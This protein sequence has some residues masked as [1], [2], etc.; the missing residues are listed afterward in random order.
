MTTFPGSQK[1]TYHYFTQ[2]YSYLE[3]KASCEDKGMTLTMPKTQVLLD[4]MANSVKANPTYVSHDAFWIGLKKRKDGKFEWVDGQVMNETLWAPWAPW[5]NRA[6]SRNGDCV[7]AWPNM[8]PPFGFYAMNGGKDGNINYV[9]EEGNY[10][11][12]FSISI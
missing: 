7:A 8:N 5:W 2:K 1:K 11:F 10:H 12:T 9:C 6:G 4:D 3:A